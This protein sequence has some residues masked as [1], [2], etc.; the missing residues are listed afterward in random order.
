MIQLNKRGE[1]KCPMCRADMTE[2]NVINVS[3]ISD[4]NN[5]PKI[6]ELLKI[7]TDGKYIIFTQFDKVIDKIQSYLSRNNITSAP[8]TD[9]NGEQV[10]L[11]SSEQNAEGIDLSHFDNMIIFEPFENNLYNKEVETQLIARIHRIGRVEPV[12]IYRFITEGTI[13][14]DIYRMK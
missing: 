9:Y 13:E 14:E 1:K 11:L 3:T 12:V 8:I 10:L 2:A 7:I 5:S 4:I 6:H